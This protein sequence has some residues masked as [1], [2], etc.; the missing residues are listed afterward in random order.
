MNLYELLDVSR[1]A[2]HR[3]IKKN[4]RRLLSSDGLC[5]EQFTVIEDAYATLS[6]DQ[7]RQAYDEK[8]E[9]EDT[10]PQSTLPVAES[11][12]LVEKPTPVETGFPETGFHSSPHEPSHKRRRRLNANPARTFISCVAAALAAG[13]IALFILKFVF[14]KD[15]LNLWKEPLVPIT[16]RRPVDPGNIRV[17]PP[18]ITSSDINNSNDVQRNGKPP[19]TEP[20]EATKLVIPLLQKQEPSQANISMPQTE[21]TA[22]PGNNKPAQ[23]SDTADRTRDQRRPV[24]T[25]NELAGPLSRLERFFSDDYREAKATADPK[26]QSVALVALAKKLFMNGK[27]VLLQDSDGV[28]VNEKS[29]ERYAWYHVA[30]MITVKADD[31]DQVEQIC[32]SLTG[33]Y[34]LDDYELSNEITLA[35]FEDVLARSEGKTSQFLDA[36]KLLFQESLT[37]SLISI[38]ADNKTAAVAQLELT[39]RILEQLKPELYL[40]PSDRIRLNNL[41]TK[42]FDECLSNSTQ[43]IQNRHFKL[44]FHVLQIAKHIAT[45]GRGENE[46][47]IVDKLIA[48]NSRFLQ[49]YE[50]YEDAR[51]KYAAS[52]DDPTI[53]SAIAKYTVLILDNWTDGLF[54]LARGDDTTLA[55]IAKL[56]NQATAAAIA[57]KAPVIFSVEQQLA[58]QWRAL[59][60]TRDQDVNRKEIVLRRTNFWYEQTFPDLTPLQKLETKK[61]LNDLNTG[62]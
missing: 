29:I 25:T 55:N 35:R 59:Y 21:T 24:P 57:S 28:I 39:R 36:W 19:G 47:S 16:A 3:E 41:L 18:R 9:S 17:P 43:Y 22:E 20:E 52:P 58:E 4:Y 15:P 33:E 30:L 50:D 34:Q 5:G 40:D 61:L 13:P 54:F 2:N 8:L 14:E 53:N 7:L 46:K 31:V 44:A 11:P 38:D 26:A 60:Q 10:A 62:A 37:N 56:D 42:M 23:P 6:D 45:I 32:E 51:L 1:T 27:L 49:L 48:Q 12:K